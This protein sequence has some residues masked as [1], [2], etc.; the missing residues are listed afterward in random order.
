[1]VQVIEN[2]Y[3][4]IDRDYFIKVLVKRLRRIEKDMSGNARKEFANFIPDGDIGKYA[5]GLPKAIKEEFTAS[6]GLLRNKDFQNVLLN[7][8]RAKHT[9]LVAVEQ[10]DEVTSERV[11]RAGGKL[12]TPED[13]H[14]GLLAVRAAEPGQGGSDQNPAGTPQE[15]EH[16]GT[17]GFE[18]DIA[19]KPVSRTDATGCPQHGFQGGV[20]RHHLDD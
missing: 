10:Q 5:A 7:Y 1:M 15:V 11:I 14:H 2:I 17:G 18:E 16:A 13:Y 20:A 19:G 8:E 12:F 3:Q 4:N 6:L 9:F